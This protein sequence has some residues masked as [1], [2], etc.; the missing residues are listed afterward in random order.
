MDSIC[1]TYGEKLNKW[2]EVQERLGLE[3]VVESS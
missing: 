3:D 1:G 2:E